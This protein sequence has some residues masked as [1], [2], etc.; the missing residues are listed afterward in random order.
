MY[1][2]KKKTADVFLFFIFAYLII[3]V[4]KISLRSVHLAIV[5]YNTG[6]FGYYCGF[7]FKECKECF[8]ILDYHINCSENL[9]YQI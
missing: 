4:I 3:F 9:K 7:S 6:K 5:L 8:W 1:L 2:N